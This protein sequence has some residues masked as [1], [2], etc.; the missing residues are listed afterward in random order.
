MI[1][2]GGPNGAKLDNQKG[3]WLQ[4]PIV[5]INPDSSGVNVIG[6]GTMETIHNTSTTR[7]SKSA[8]PKPIDVTWTD[9]M[10][11]DGAANIADVYGHVFVKN[12]DAVGTVST[13]TG[14]K[15]H[16]DLMDAPK[17]TTKKSPT[18]QPDSLGSAMGGKQLKILTLTGHVV[19]ESELLGADGGL[20][21]QDTLHGNQLVYN[22]VNGTAIVPGPG[23]LLVEN[24]RADAKDGANNRGRMAVSWQKQLTYTQPTQ[25]INIDGDTVVGFEKDPAGKEAGKPPGTPMQLRGQHLII[26]LA[27][28]PSAATK[29]AAESQGKLQ[30]SHMQANGQVM[31]NAQG[32]DFSCDQVDYDP[33][34]ALMTAIGHGRTL[35]ADQT[36]SGTFD[37]LIYDT[38]M[39][40]VKQIKGSQVKVQR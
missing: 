32:A 31:F 37:E 25:I 17:A 5:K 9:S 24:H 10:S 34:T 40:E 23:W 30:L 39:E 13:I 36:L 18:T 11:L 16:I 22:A 7:P 26:T 35:N 29:P 20:A 2:L 27:K 19:G 28:A 6:P 4:G 1:E 33:K 14:D 8:P 12:T 15:A 38:V 3:S 21:R